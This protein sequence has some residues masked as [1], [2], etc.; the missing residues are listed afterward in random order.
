MDQYSRRIIGFGVH[1]GAVDGVALCR[2]FIRTLTAKKGQPYRFGGDEIVVL[3]PDHSGQEATTLA[4]RI[5][6]RVERLSFER[7]PE[8]LTLSIGVAAYCI[9]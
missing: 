2:M 5:L 1:A 6:Q 9:C 3:L 7:Y 8:A 4:E